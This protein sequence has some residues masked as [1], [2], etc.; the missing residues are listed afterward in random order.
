M[1][2]VVYQNPINAI[3]GKTVLF[4]LLKKR[5]PEKQKER[6]KKKKN[7]TQ[8]EERENERTEQNE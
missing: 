7:T 2:S 5:M 3:L 8:K 4:K 1:L 6:E